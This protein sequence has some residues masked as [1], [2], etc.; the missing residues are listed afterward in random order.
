MAQPLYA[1]RPASPQVSLH[2]KEMV[3]AC[4]E[5]RLVD[6]QRLFDEHHVKH[7]EDPVSYWD[8]T[9]DGAP[10]T[11]KLFA[12]AISRKQ[13]SVVRYLHTVYPKFD[14]CD[15]ITL[16]ALAESSDLDLLKMIYSYSP[17]IVGY[18][19]RDGSS[20]TFLGKTCEVGPQNAP[21][22]A[23]LMDHGAWDPNPLDYRYFLGLELLPAVKHDQ[24]IEIIK[25]MTP[26]TANL[27]YPIRIA[28]Y[29]RRADVLEFLLREDETRARSGQT[30]SIQYLQSLM[31]AAQ[32]TQDKEIISLVQRHSRSF[33]QKAAQDIPVKVE[34]TRTWWQFLTGARSKSKPAERSNSSQ[35]EDQ[36]KELCETTSVEETEDA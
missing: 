8:A 17:K 29:R 11:C 22:V 9:Q 4:E 32:D 20:T 1:P 15:A 5:G 28:V 31:E 36:K 2:Q 18:V 7:E 27:G 16:N 13:Q 35:R 21:L 26:Q 3:K 10:A 34:S 33:E 24:P 19:Y 6:L 14:F 23:F 30:H 12:A 25:K